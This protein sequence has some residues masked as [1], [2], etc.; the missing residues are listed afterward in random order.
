MIFVTL[1]TNDKEFRRPLI[2]LDRL[3]KDGVIKEHIVVQA[4]YTK[5]N[6]DN[7]EIFDTLDI[8][9]FKKYMNECDLLITHGGIGSI[10]DALYYNK[11]VIAIPRLAKYKEHV[12]DHQLDIVNEF[13]NLGYLLKVEDIKD[14]E[15]VYLEAKKRKPVKLKNNNYKMIKIITDFIDKK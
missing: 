11:R 12:N 5:Y 7:M 9:T 10:T 15:K 6:S 3:V 1:G 14:L 4:G 8:K 13:Y 2:E